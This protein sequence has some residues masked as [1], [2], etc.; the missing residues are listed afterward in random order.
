M[1]GTAA[2]GCPAREARQRFAKIK[3]ASSLDEAF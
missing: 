2:V 1:W 3:K